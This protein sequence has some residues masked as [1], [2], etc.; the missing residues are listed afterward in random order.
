[1][2]LRVRFTRLPAVRTLTLGCVLVILCGFSPGRGQGLTRDGI[3]VG[4]VVE[5]LEKNEA[6]HVVGFEFLNGSRDKMADADAVMTALRQLDFVKLRR[7]M[8]VETDYEC[9]TGEDYVVIMPKDD[10]VSH[11]VALAKR[12]VVFPKAINVPIND[13]LA[14]VQAANAPTLAI[15]LGGP[16]MFHSQVNGAISTEGGQ[17][18]CYLILN[19]LTLKLKARSWCIEHL[20][21]NT[22]RTSQP[23]KPIKLG[24][25][26]VS[27]YARPSLGWVDARR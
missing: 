3:L 12:L 16:L 27:I 15:H 14:Q 21:F 11:D 5:Q 17:D 25:G 4:E 2:E 22:A 1:M 10:P 19:A 24:A 8:A 13:F 6:L 7:M 26:N 23:E 9:L 20:I 18:F